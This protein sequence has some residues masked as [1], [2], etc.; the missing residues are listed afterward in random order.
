MADTKIDL[1]DAYRSLDDL[2]SRIRSLLHGA[3]TSARHEEDQDAEVDM[4]T[5][6][7][8]LAEEARSFV[9]RLDMATRG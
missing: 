2:L 9:E 3:I 1:Q 5:I 7:K 6:A 4:L 8:E